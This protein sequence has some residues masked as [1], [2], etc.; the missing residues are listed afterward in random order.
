[1]RTLGCVLGGAVGV[2]TA[3]LALAPLA[4]SAGDDPGD[5]SDS[6]A[7]IL[8][9]EDDSASSSSSSDSEA[10]RRRQKVWRGCGRPMCSYVVMHQAAT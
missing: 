8:E 10:E 3:A 7:S 9:S 5:S 4:A 1:M 2:P 6:L